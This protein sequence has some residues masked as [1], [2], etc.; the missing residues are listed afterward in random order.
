MQPA[1]IALVCLLLL[2]L[3]TPTHP[4]FCGAGRYIDG[5]TG[6]CAQCPLPTQYSPGGTVTTCSACAPGTM[7]SG[8]ACVAC[9]AGKFS[10]AWASTACT[11][12]PSGTA[13]VA[14]SSACVRCDATGSAKLANGLTACPACTTTCTACVAGRY[15]DGTT[16]KCSS[17]AAGKFSMEVKAVS[18]RT[19]TPCATGQTTLPT[20]TGASACVPCNETNILN[21]RS[22]K[23]AS[24]ADP[25]ECAW[26][27]NTGYTRFNFSET[28]YAPATYT[29]LGYS[30]SQALAIFHNRNDFCCEPSPVLTGMYM[31]GPY[32][33]T[34]TPACT[35]STD[36]DASACVPVPNAHFIGGGT[37][38]FNRCADWLCDDYFFLNQTNGVCTAQPTCA[39]DFTYQRDATS[40]LY[41]VQPSGSFTCVPC[42]RCIDGSETATPCTQRNDTVC[43]ICA[44]TEFSYLAGRCTPSIPSGFGPVRVRLTSTPVYQGR[45][46]TFYDAT[47][48][49]WNQIDYTQGFF[50]NTYTPCHPLALQALMF[51]GGDEICNRMDISPSSLCALPL[52]KT[53][54]KPWNGAEGWY[55]L[56]SGD[57]S[58][59][60]YDTTCSSVQ[61]SDMTTCGPNTAPR[62]LPCPLLPLPNSLGWLNPGR[63]PFPGPYPCDILCR[64]GFAKGSN[65]SCIPCPS[66]PN[67]SKITG[68][69]NWTCSLGFVQDRSTCIPCVGVPASCA[70]GYYLGYAAATSQCARCLPCTN[71]VANAVYISAG[72]PNGPNTCA[73][74]CISN[75]F[76]SPGYGFDTYNNPVACDRCS[77]PTCIAGT[78]FLRPCSYL[79]D[80]EC[81]ACSVCPVGMRT[82]AP[83]TPTTNTPC[84]PCPAA[85]DNATWTG[86][87]C[88][89]WRCDQGFTL[90]PNSSTCLKC[91]S[92]RDCIY[93][94]TYE[95]DSDGAGCGRCVACDLFLLLPGQCFNGDGQCG[96]SYWCDPGVVVAPT[97]PPLVEATPLETV[98]EAAMMEDILL[99]DQAT[100]PILAY[101]SMATLALADT[102]TAALLTALEATLSTECNCTATVAAITHDNTTAFCSPATPCVLGRR[103]RHLLADLFYYIDITLVSRVQLTHPPAQPT[104]PHIANW[105]T[106]TCQPITDPSLLR[107]RRRMAVYFRRS[108]TPWI[109]PQ[110]VQWTEY[111]LILGIIVV[112]CALLLAAGG[113]TVYYVR[114]YE[115]R[116]AGTEVCNGRK[117]GHRRA[118]SIGSEHDLLLPDKWRV[119]KEG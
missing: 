6:Y 33:P 39:A 117:R 45:P 79:A 21:P 72:Q 67:N 102:P 76:V 31:C 15:N 26:T 62:C 37:N 55:R 113:G 87:E 10:G 28:T 61:F 69:C 58:K 7:I 24:S 95:D 19:C 88:A 5:A 27:C 43:R 108:G 12:C 29:A 1:R 34:C 105:Q 41:V 17:C 42:S 73:I 46:S 16:K 81:V 35:R 3:L 118:R 96:V 8:T 68:G 59:C 9:A 14:S 91:K 63:T 90:E 106:Y 13:S 56:K 94:D 32:T 30:T 51:T 38:R 114:V 74:R 71:L 84:T 65:Y 93:S 119:N 86:P 83:C 101:A 85:P 80:T 11:A 99:Q 116:S 109:Q 20:T 22:A 18:S 77:T 49:L 48:V 23:Y 52:C 104:L 89:R 60:I 82:L 78:S 103:R 107:D 47:P 53:Q 25:L 70:T 66:M 115:V 40:G 64:D 97:P 54:C 111:Y 57:C 44:P 2:H 98:A 110:P 36:G 75:T 100:S 112:A 4:A 50:L 92:P